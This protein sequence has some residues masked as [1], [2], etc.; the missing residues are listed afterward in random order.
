[1][2]LKLCLLNLSIPSTWLMVA[3]TKKCLKQ[4]R[5]SLD[6]FP[7]ICAISGT[8]SMQRLGSQV[9]ENKFETSP[10]LFYFSTYGPTSAL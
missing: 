6:K 9:S 8:K 2:F 4:I 7:S 3:Q 1:M 10:L 5:L